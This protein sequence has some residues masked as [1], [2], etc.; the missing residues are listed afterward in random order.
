MKRELAEVRARQ[1]LPADISHLTMSPDMNSFHQTSTNSF[2]QSASTAELSEL[3]PEAQ[4]I[5]EERAAHAE[6]MNALQS[7]D[8]LVSC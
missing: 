3:T 6:T 8:E 5:I 2:H 7:C 4:K 1:A